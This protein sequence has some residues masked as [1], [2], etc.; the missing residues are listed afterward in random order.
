[1][2][3]TILTQSYHTNESPVKLC[4]DSPNSQT[5]DNQITEQL[6]QEG[7]RLASLNEAGWT[8]T[9]M[10]DGERVTI[11]VTDLGGEL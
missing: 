4:A 1:M 11:W 3:N 9:Y 5:S 8:Y 6:A 7:L 10:D 2:S